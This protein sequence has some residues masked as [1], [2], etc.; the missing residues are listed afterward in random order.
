MTDSFAIKT[1]DWL[2]DHKEEFEF[3]EKQF[4]EFKTH[5]PKLVKIFLDLKD[6]GIQKK[7]G[8]EFTTE[9]CTL[10]DVAEFVVKDLAEKNINVVLT[11]KDS[12][13]VLGFLHFK[14]I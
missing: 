1:S 12:K 14:Q 13:D 10:D 3:D 11:K 9:Y 4:E 2:E 8:T 5:K 6:K 7:L